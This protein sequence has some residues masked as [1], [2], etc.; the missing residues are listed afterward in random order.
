MV[1]RRKLGG[2]SERAPACE[3]M[4]PD[5]LG[6]SLRSDRAPRGGAVGALLLLLLCVRAMGTEKRCYPG[7]DVRPSGSFGRAGRRLAIRPA[8]VYRLDSRELR[9]IAR[10]GH[11]D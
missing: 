9:S 10:P 7:R 3:W 5:P 6:H 4:V 1:A 2:V 8:R 11:R